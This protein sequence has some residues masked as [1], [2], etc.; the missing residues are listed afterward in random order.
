[1]IIDRM[2]ALFDR[3]ANP[4]LLVRKITIGANH[5]LHESDVP[6]APEQEQL[7]LF[8]DYE[9]LEKQKAVEDA[10]QAKERRLQDALLDI[11]KRFGKNAVL[12]AMSL[13]DGAT[14][15]ER[16]KQVGEVT[17]NEPIRRYYRP[18]A[19]RFAHASADVAARS[20]GTVCAFRGTGGLR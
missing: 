19:P 18:A 4:D 8:V 16:N 6:P 7:D 3:I 10:E 9:A 14:A 12:K 1:M 17:R 5:V 20:R 15:K 2:M 11:K 13:Q